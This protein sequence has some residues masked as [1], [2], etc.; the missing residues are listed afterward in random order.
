MQVPARSFSGKN[1]ANTIFSDGEAVHARN[2]P[3]TLEGVFCGGGRLRKTGV[4][5]DVGRAAHHRHSGS[6]A[7]AGGARAAN[8]AHQ[9]CCADFHEQNSEREVERVHCGTGAGRSGW[10]R[11]FTTPGGRTTPS[12]I[13]PR[14]SSTKTGPKPLRSPWGPL[15]SSPRKSAAFR[16]NFWKPPL[17]A[18]QP[19]PLR[20]VACS[21]FRSS[22]QKSHPAP[23]STLHPCRRLPIAVHFSHTQPP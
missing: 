16:H 4:G 19:T 17:Q 18:L 9:R 13:S 15:L 22:F 5:L 23:S 7:A 6:R 1:Q 3:G 8:S 11:R 2:A 14:R 10:G 12:A 20:S 21:A